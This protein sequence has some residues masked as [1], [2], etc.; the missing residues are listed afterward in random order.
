MEVRPITGSLSV[1]VLIHPPDRRRR[2][3][4]NVLK[5]LLDALQHGGAYEDDNQ[6]VDLSIHKRCPIK[7]GKAIV[8]IEETDGRLC[9]QL[10]PRK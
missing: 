8:R 6:I 7:G 10:S 5:A 2:D 4:D 9:P 3:I 1:D